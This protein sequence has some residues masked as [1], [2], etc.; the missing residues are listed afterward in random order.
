MK[1]HELKTWPVFYKDIVN[2]TKT[3]EVRQNDRDFQ[4]GDLLL[5]REYDPDAEQYTG[6]KTERV[7]TYILGDN[8]FFQLNAMVILGIPPLPQQEPERSA[9][10]ILMKHVDCTTVEY[11][12]PLIIE[13]MEEYAQIKLLPVPSVTITDEEIETKAHELA[14]FTGYDGKYNVNTKVEV[15]CIRMGKWVISQLPAKETIK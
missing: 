5:L 13:A 15:N 8:P 10:D 7:I 12:W 2:G 11:N 6:A 3:F 4:L 9:D 1:T 14:L